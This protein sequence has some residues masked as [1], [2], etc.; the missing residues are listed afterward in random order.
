MRPC[1]WTRSMRPC[2][3]T[4]SGS[5]CWWTRSGRP[6]W[7]T[8]SGIPCWW[9]LFF[10]PLCFPSQNQRKPLQVQQYRFLLSQQSF[11]RSACYHRCL[12]CRSHR[13]N[14]PH[15]SGSCRLG[16]SMQ[17]HPT[18]TRRRGSR[19]CIVLRWVPRRSCRFHTGNHGISGLYQ[20]PCTP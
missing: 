7:W 2:W 20:S 17:I 14:P 1:W 4:R 15:S 11:Y 16:R 5:P 3:W 18:G 8:R 13:P 9:T 6:C 19:C 10:R 12:S